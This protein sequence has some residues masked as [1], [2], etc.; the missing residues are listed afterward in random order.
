MLVYPAIDIIEGQ[1][2]RLTRG[3]FDQKKKYFDDP[4]EVAE[5]WKQKG[6]VWIHVIDLDGAR[7]GRAANL[8]VASAIKESSMY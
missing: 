8:P 5:K 3:D 6:A 4:L 7:T 1:C 2:V